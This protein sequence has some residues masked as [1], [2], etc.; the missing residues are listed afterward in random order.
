MSDIAIAH[1]D[2][3]TNGGG[4]HVAEALAQDFAAPLLVGHENRE[5]QPEDMDIR[6]IGPESR[7]HWLIER[8][9]LPRALANMF[10]WRDYGPEYLAEYDI[11]YFEEDGRAKK[12][13]VPYD[14]VRIEVEFGLPRG[15]GSESAASA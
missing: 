6:E 9:G 13:Y 12:P 14:T 7:Y 2:Y 1:K 8:G 15:E 4:E 11:I 3:N 10:L 5:N